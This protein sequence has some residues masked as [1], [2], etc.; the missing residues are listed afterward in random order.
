MIAY[1]NLFLISIIFLVKNEVPQEIK[2]TANYNLTA[3]SATIVLPYALTEISGITGI[4]STTFACVQDEI[5]IVFIYDSR[6]G[7][8]I[9][10]IPF[11]GPG[12]Y[13]GI[14][15]V[16]RS[17]YILR[18]D[19][20]LYEL[21]DYLVKSPVINIFNTGIPAKDNEGLCYDSRNKRLLI[22]CK[23]GYTEDE[24]KNKQLVYSFDLKTKKLSKDPVIV[25]DIKVLRKIVKEND[26][27]IPGIDK[28]DVDDLDFRASDIGIN[29]LTGKIFLISA[30]FYTL[31]V[32]DMSG[33]VETI[34]PLKKD[35]FRQAEGIT[36]NSRGDLF[37]SNEAAGKSPTLVRFNYVKAPST[38]TIH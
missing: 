24:I 13:E 11:A 14:T 12:D 1:L 38:V 36:F 19:G 16:N 7:Q 4:D 26:I 18:S 30:S 22:A 31:I 25:L 17:L 3:P 27:K 10:Q 2:R 29:P 33:R 20:I 23:Q 37:I 34:A 8:I 15:R 5:G 35:L 6:K 9:N 21:A 28:D 32:A